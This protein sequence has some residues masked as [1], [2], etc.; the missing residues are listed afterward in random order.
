MQI[1]ASPMVLNIASI[2]KNAICRLRWRN[3][4]KST[5]EVQFFPKKDLSFHHL[6]GWYPPDQLILRVSSCA[7]AFPLLLMED[8]HCSSQSCLCSRL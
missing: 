6:S 7:H 3:G 2:A 5:I 8:A 1:Q 4:R